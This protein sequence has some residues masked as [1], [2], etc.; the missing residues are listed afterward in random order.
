[1]RILCVVL[2]I[3]SIGFVFSQE[4]QKTTFKGEEVFKTESGLMYKIIEKG[5]GPRVKKGDVVYTHYTLRLEDGKKIDSSLDRNMPFFLKLGASEVIKG[6]DEG[7]SYM[8]IGD[9]RKL[10]IPPDLGYGVRGAGDAVPPNATLFFEV[11]LLANENIK[12]KGEDYVKT[13]T[14]LMYK[15]IKV[16]KGETPLRGQTVVAHYTGWLENGKKFDSSLDRKKPY[17]FQIQTRSVIPGWDEGF[18]SMKPGGK[19]KLIIPS[20]LGYGSSGRGSIPPNAT[21]IFEVEMLEIK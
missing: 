16:G 6:W 7:L 14:G 15:D 1:M 2:L 20:N 10:I 18:K 12:Y 5:K 9:K 13:P 17:P 3:L 11:E 19:R 4:H 21:L 8:N